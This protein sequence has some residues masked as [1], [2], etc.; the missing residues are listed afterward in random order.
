MSVISTVNIDCVRDTLQ[1][2][3]DDLSIESTVQLPS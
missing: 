3:T 1:M 2:Q